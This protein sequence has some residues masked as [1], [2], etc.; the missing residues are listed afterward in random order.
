MNKTRKTAIATDDYLDLVRRFPLRPIRNEAD[1]D[2]AIEIL[3]SLVSRADEELSHGE[4]DYADALGH[5]VDLYENAHYPL[6]NEL[7]TPLER[8]K[9]L[10]RLHEMKAPGLGRLLGSSSAQA[11]QILNGKHE[12]SKSDI[13]LLA[14]HFK[15]SPALFI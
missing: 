10:M 11:S 8:L 3:K 1:Y 14:D 7:H 6:E 2:T 12:L 4:S 13:R 5:F 15:V 9:F